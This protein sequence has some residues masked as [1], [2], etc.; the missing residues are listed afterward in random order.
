MQIKKAQSTP[1]AVT[2]TVTADEK[3]LS[4][5]KQQV[6]AELGSNTKV[7]GFRAGKA[8]AH[9][10]EKQLDQDV[11]HTEFLDA[12]VNQLFVSAIEHEKL[13][14]VTQ[15][16]ISITKFV[17]FTTLEFTAELSVIGDIV[18]A[19]YKTIKLTIPKATVTAADV[20]DV[21]ETLRSRS[22]ERKKVTRAAKLG[23]ELLID[24]VGTDTVTKK[25]IEG[26]SAADHVLLLG[27]KSLIEGFESGLVGVKAGDTKTLALKFP[28]DYAAVELQKKKV[29]FEVTV[30][31]VRE[32]VL[33][34]FDDTFVKTIGP[35]KTVDEAKAAIKQDILRERDRENQTAFENE[36]LNKLVEK[37]TIPIPDSLIN[38][39]IDRM[40][41][42]EKRN[43][44]YR[45]QTWQEH[46]DSEGV[47]AE[48]HRDRQRPMAETRVKGGVI[49][50]E[51]ASKEKITVSPEELEIRM[52][53]LKNQYPDPAMQEELEKPESRRDINN[54]LLTEKTLDTLRTYVT[55]K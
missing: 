27:S 6:I 54:R 51:V 29:S 50:A 40:E 3:E 35:F 23:D 9:L 28:A 39:E 41:E 48:A 36:L 5:L 49:L 33:P 31:E 16:N 43:L 19:N 46:L 34:K 24:F 32:L 12:A 4:G 37:S 15:P 45:G 42:E 7:A 44:T 55:K 2:I 8:P 30:K 17:P 13:K 52:M 18:L 38:E 11:L 21:I 25:P 20:Q 53:L 47:T 14:P 10:I 26:G 1:T 22:A